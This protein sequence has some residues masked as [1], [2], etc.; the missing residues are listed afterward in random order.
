MRET[1]YAG[2]CWGARKESAEECAR[3]AEAFFHLLSSLPEPVRVQPVE[4]KG[5]LLLLT[6]ER[7]TASNPEHLALGRHVQEVLRARGML[8]PVVSRRPAT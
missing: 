1:Y 4:D 3:R 2:I 6:P 8:E 7:L 5:T